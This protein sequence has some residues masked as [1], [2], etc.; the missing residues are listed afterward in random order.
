METILNALDNKADYQ[1]VE[2]LQREVDE[3]VERADF[4]HLV[5][6]LS[7]KADK[8]DI[9]ELANSV[10]DL[11]SDNEQTS[12]QYHK[13]F[14][15]LTHL[16]ETMTESLQNQLASKADLKE[17]DRIV[18]VLTQKVDSEQFEGAVDHLK[19][20]VANQLD[21][22]REELLALQNEMRNAASDGDQKLKNY[23]NKLF[24]EIYRATDQFQSKLQEMDKKAEKK[25]TALQN[26]QIIPHQNEESPKQA[27]DSH[28][29][30]ESES[31]EE[32]RQLM[33]ERMSKK[34]DKEEFLAITEK[35]L[36]ELHNKADLADVQQA[37]NNCQKDIITH[38]SEYRTE[39]SFLIKRHESQLLNAIEK[40][41]SLEEVATALSS[42]PD[43]DLVQQAL[44]KKIGVDDFYTLKKSFE[45]AIADLEQRLIEISNKNQS[46]E[47][48]ESFD[49]I[50]K[51]LVEF[52]KKIL[53]KANIKDVCA[54]LDAKSSTIMI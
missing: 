53:S 19:N 48:H 36:T 3:K 37:L 23:Y 7:S 4:D 26:G 28:H 24:D 43:A 38:F 34:L 9:E 50:K 33:E 29:S 5:S 40:K 13:H 2:K 21:E 12:N 15:H 51:Q 35:I 39:V 10:E 52:D 11:K 44:G 8:G 18:G 27:S 25:E 22:F 17:L 32:L 6:I 20:D 30:H 54:L 46:L 1:A 31:K 14:E 42:K 41:A 45:I 16:I 47:S 49:E